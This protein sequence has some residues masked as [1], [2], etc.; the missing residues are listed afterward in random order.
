MFLVFYF[1]R[2]MLDKTDRHQ[3]P[4]TVTDYLDTLDVRVAGQ[5]DSERACHIGARIVRAMKS[6]PTME[7]RWRVFIVRR[8]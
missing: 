7:E 8:L 4:V 3:S 1:L 5:Y 2:P 6:V